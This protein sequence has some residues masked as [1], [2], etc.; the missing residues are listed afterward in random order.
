MRAICIA[1]KAIFLCFQVLL[2]FVP[3][4]LHFLY[5]PLPLLRQDVSAFPDGRGAI[6]AASDELSIV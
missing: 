6:T 4:I 2:S 1:K 5:L 3:T